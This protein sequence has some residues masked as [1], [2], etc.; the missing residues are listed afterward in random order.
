MT[1]GSLQTHSITFIRHGNETDVPYGDEYG[2]VVTPTTE[3]E[4]ETCGSLQPVSAMERR[5]GLSEGFR[6]EDTYKY[7]T[8]SNLRTTDQ[9][10]NLLPDICTISGR[11]YKITRKGD[12]EG[13]GLSVDHNTYYLALVNPEGS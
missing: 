9:F 7:Y 10:T 12:W 13:F 3:L 2:D 11:K 1:I 5:V 6:T 4:I 8:T